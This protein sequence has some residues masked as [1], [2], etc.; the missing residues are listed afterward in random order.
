MRQMSNKTS[1]I[2]TEEA[3]AGSRGKLD[4]RGEGKNVEINENETETS[5][6]EMD[7]NVNFYCQC[8]SS[9]DKF[10]APT[11]IENFRHSS[12]CC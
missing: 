10:K 5:Q 1:K 4:Q 12:A 3:N 6:C 11:S 2:I 8:A 7:E 9:G